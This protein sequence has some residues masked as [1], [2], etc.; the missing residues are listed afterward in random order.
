MD[1]FIYIYSDLYQHHH[2]YVSKC[3]SLGGIPYQSIKINDIPKSRESGHTFAKGESVKLDMLVKSIEDNINHD[4]VFSD[5][6]IGFNPDK[7]TQVK[8]YFNQYR[9]YDLCWQYN[10][11]P[12]TGFNIGITKV[13]CN[14]KMLDF[15]REVR[16]VTIK[17]KRW[18]QWNCNQLY[19]QNETNINFKVFSDKLVANGG[20]K[21]LDPEIRKEFYIWKQLLSHENKT[22]EEIA[23]KRIEQLKSHQLLV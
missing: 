18:D 7:I 16:D 13:K 6:T 14:S 11:C 15:F 17:N 21:L 20:W 23:A 19:K 1:K 4:I 22:P 12:D 3:L 2:E 10:N 8:D 5:V 9:G